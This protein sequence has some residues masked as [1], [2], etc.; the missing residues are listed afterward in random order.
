MERKT[1]K[2]DVSD[3]SPGRVA[4]EVVNLLRGKNKPDFVYNEDK[5]SFVEIE[6]IK[7][8][9]FT[10]KKLD[11]KKYYKYSGYPGG[12]KEKVMGDVFKENPGEVL[13]KAV[14]KMLPK[15]KLRKEMIKR[16]SFKS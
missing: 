4:T 15:N 10:G 12:L 7:N 16:L 8:L 11:Q 9:K 14:Y 5:G 13:K 2:I 3:R 1:Y 6:N